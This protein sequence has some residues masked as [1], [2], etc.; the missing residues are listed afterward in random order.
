MAF[1]PN[2]G[3]PNDTD[4]KFCTNCGN[5]LVS[6][7]TA[8]KIEELE[9]TSTKKE[10]FISPGSILL[11]GLFLSMLCAMIFTSINLKRRGL[12]KSWMFMLLSA[13]LGFATFIYGA[14]VFELS[15]TIILVVSLVVTFILFAFEKVL[16]DNPERAKRIALKDKS[17]MWTSLSLS[18]IFVIFSIWATLH[19]FNTTTTVQFGSGTN[20]DGSLTGIAQEFSS[21]QSIYINFWKSKGTFNSSNINMKMLDMEDS[22]QLIG[23]FDSSVD[24]TWEGASF[25]LV[26]GYFD[27]LSSGKYKL[28]IFI[29]DKLISEGNFSLK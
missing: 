7:E 19:S 27:N 20:S 22:E 15:N 1:C 4:S 21:D 14:L 11:A 25:Q 13:C 24:P 29:K 26:P 17:C 28:R 10:E 6:Q 12:K 16:Q 23:D 3:A 18:A 2:C 5:S 9:K 8:N